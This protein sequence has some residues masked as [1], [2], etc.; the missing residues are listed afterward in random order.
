[1]NGRVTYPNARQSRYL[2]RIHLI[3][4]IAYS[5]LADAVVAPAVHVAGIG[6]R[7]AGS[8]A[9]GDAYNL[10]PGQDRVH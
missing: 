3:H 8:L 9:A 5:Q 4:V 2:D 7:H 1:M 10:L 6:D